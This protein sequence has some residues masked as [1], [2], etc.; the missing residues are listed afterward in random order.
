M[1]F[2]E[3]EKELVQNFSAIG[4]DINKMIADNKLFIDYVYIERNEIEETG[5]FDLEGIFIRL[6]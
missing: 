5:E 2:E 3:T 1:S 6:E 4:Y